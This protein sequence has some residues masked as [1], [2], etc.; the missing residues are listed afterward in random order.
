MGLV[1]PA[2]GADAVPPADADPS[3]RGGEALGPGGALAGQRSAGGP[4]AVIAVAVGGLP[5]TV[6][7]CS[8]PDASEESAAGPLE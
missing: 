4:V 7:N 8:A 2:E 5:S 1:V 3:Q 6:M